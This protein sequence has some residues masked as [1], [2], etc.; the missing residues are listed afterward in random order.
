[1]LNVNVNVKIAPV[2]LIIV[3][4]RKVLGGQGS[5]KATLFTEMR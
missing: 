3:S 2:F 1:M 5:L 4:L